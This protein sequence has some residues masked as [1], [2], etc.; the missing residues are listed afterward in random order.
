MTR[1]PDVKK[2]TATAERVTQDDRE[3]FQD[4]LYMAGAQFDTENA[5][6][7]HHNE[8]HQL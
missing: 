3:S 2:K 4:L 8:P 5:G 1:S 7:S 6:S